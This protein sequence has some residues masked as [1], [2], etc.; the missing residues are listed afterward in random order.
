LKEAARV[1]GGRGRAMGFESTFAARVG[2]CNLSFVRDSRAQS[3]KNAAVRFGDYLPVGFVD[4]SGLSS[5]TAGTPQE[6]ESIDT[7][8]WPGMQRHQEVSTKGF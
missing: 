4:R 6:S 5:S 2:L 8:L 3:P 7:L 1:C